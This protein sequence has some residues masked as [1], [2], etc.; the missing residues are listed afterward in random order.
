M[1][2][3]L[4][5]LLLTPPP[6]PPHPLAPCLFDPHRG[7][8]L[9]RSPSLSLLRLLLSSSHLRT[10]RRPPAAASRPDRSA[11]KEGVVSTSLRASQ[12][13]APNVSALRKRRRARLLPRR[14][15]SAAN[16]TRDVFYASLHF[17]KNI[18]SRFQRLTDF[19]FRFL[20]YGEDG[21]TMSIMLY[22]ILTQSTRNITR[23]CSTATLL[24]ASP[25]EFYFCL[26]QDKL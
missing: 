23:P 20:R 16:L 5:K 7:A 11:P 15:A 2:F 8:S 24:L 19:S 25:D 3:Y 18:C 1:I 6:T 17:E 22:V 9:L 12:A 26:R 14:R 21:G 13:Q 10:L 4:L